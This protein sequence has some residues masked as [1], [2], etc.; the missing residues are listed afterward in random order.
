A[1]KTILKVK[2]LSP[3]LEEKSIQVRSEGSFTILSVNHKLN[4]LHELEKDETIDSLHKII[5]SIESNISINDDRLNVLKEK[6]DLLDENKKLGSPN[7]GITLVQLKQA[8]EFYEEEMSKIE[9][10]QLKIRT[11]SA[12]YL[13]DKEAIERQK[14]EI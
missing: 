10:E 5:E 6:R 8:I 1:G 4:Y 11:R 14:K 13:L 9:Q 3:F 12:K 7:S 2:N